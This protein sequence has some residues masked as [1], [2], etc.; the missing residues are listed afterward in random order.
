[1]DETKRQAFHDAHA[2][3]SCLSTFK[4]IL[5]K[6]EKK[7]ADDYKK[8]ISKI[9]KLKENNEA[10]KREMEKKL[11]A[12]TKEKDKENEEIKRKFSEERNTFENR[13]KE[14]E[15][16]NYELKKDNNKCMEQPVTYRKSLE[17]ETIERED[18]KDYKQVCIK[19]TE[20]KKWREELQTR[21]EL[22][23]EENA[24]IKERVKKVER[25]QD[26]VQIE[27]VEGDIRNKE[28]NDSMP[29]KTDHSIYP[30]SGIQ[31]QMTNVET[32]K[33]EGTTS[34]NHLADT[35]AIQRRNAGQTCTSSL[36]V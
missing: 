3:S 34:I 23:E 17:K 13:I 26:R 28:H 5:D 27:K 24:E 9:K 10:V 18:F 33:R 14:L 15:K 30:R 8:N 31:G 4:D 36:F 21:V 22:L 7:T 2:I 11:R 1:M 12:N 6:Q 32:P 25:K 19:W 16:L 29:N 20:E 35:T